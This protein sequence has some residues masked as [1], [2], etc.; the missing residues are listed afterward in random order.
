MQAAFFKL[1]RNDFVK[2][3]V[4]AVLG[5]VAAT[6]AQ[7]LNAPGF[8]FYTFQWGEVAR[9]AEGAFFAYMAKNLLSTQDGKFMGV[10]GR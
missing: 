10:V 3:A 6:I 5:A 8:D 2:G 4:V 7:A 9:V 1:T